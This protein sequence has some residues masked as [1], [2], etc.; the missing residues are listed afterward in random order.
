MHTLKMLLCLMAIFPMFTACDLNDKITEEEA[1]KAGL[2]LVDLNNQGNG[3]VGK[4]KLIQ[5]NGFIESSDTKAELWGVFQSEKDS[6]CVMSGA[7]NFMKP[8]AGDWTLTGYNFHGDHGINCVWSKE[9]VG[10]KIPR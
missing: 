8:K 10:Y 3:E 1:K 7:F 5:W 2:H 4:I 6:S 9:F